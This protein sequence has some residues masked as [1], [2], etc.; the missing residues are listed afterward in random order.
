LI[1][2]LGNS[3]IYISLIVTTLFYINYLTKIIPST[4][5]SLRLIYFIN[6]IPF[7]L[8]VYAFS[9]SDLTLLNVV[10][11]SYINDPI[12]YKITSAWGSHEGSILL[13]IFLINLFG[14][15]F[16]NKNRTV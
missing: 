9:I 2:F 8:L 15:F 5:V 11:N 1:S 14:V 13:W 10:E 12:F 7:S 16:L 4:T 6:L 3:I